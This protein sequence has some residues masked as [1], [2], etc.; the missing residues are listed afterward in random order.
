MIHASHKVRANEPVEVVISINARYL[1]KNSLDSLV[2]RANPEDMSTAEGAAPDADL[3]GVD[4]TSALR[5]GDRIG[6]VT[7]LLC[8]DD[9]V[10]RLA[11]LGVAGAEASM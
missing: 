2:Y 10:T 8:R 9:L 3:G 11:L 5:I 7:G 1:A 4:L 6:D